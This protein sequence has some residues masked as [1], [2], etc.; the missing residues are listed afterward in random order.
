MKLY[1]LSVGD[2]FEFLSKHRNKT[3]QIKERTT[4]NIVYKDLGTDE[5]RSAPSNRK[6]FYFEVT[7]METSN[8]IDLSSEESRLLI[9][10]LN[11]A[12][13]LS[14]EYCDPEIRRSIIDKIYRKIKN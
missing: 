3:F 7:L 13:K 12:Y 5:E 6:A 2:K 14:S 10:I 9:E 8:S 11:E 4:H 1:E